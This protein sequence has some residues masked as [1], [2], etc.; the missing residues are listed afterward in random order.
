MSTQL[1]LGIV[2]VL[3]L[4]TCAYQFRRLDRHDKKSHPQQQSTSHDIDQ[5]S[6]VDN[7]PE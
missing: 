6:P 5:S 1:V 3:Y 4:A 7:E 2:I